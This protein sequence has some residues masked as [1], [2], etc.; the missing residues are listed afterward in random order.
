MWMLTLI[1]VD[2]GTSLLPAVARCLM[3][4]RLDWTAAQSYCSVPQVKHPAVFPFIYSF[5]ILFINI[6]IYTI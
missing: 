3:I 6:L 1:V 5:F 2:G 4:L